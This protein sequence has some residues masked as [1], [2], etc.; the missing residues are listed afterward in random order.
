MAL[1]V[2]RSVKI[3]QHNA[4]AASGLHSYTMD[5]NHLIDHVINNLNYNELLF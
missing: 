5:E 3:E 1:Y 4:E 2:D